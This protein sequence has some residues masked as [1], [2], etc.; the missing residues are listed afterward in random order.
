[1][2][3]RQAPRV[4]AVDLDGTL[5]SDYDEFGRP[6]SE[7]NL[8]ALS[9]LRAAGT[10]ILICT[11]RSES[12][13]RSILTRSG[14]PELAA[15]DLILQNGAL[16]LEG[17]T[18]RV[19]ASRPLSKEDAAEYLAIF[20]EHEMAPMLFLHH[21]LGGACL[22]EGLVTNPRQTHYLE[23]RAKED[24]GALRRVANLEEHLE[25]DPLSLATIDYGEPIEAARRDMENLALPESR[26]AVQGLVGW[27]GGE[28]A[29][30]LEVFHRDVR[31]EI[32]F[33]EYCAARE[34]EP[35]D[36]AAIGD[37]RN[38]LGLIQLCGF[39]IAMANAPRMVREAAD[40]IAPHYNES[41][42]ATA[43]RECFGL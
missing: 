35:A 13:A 16:V 22:Y 6:V 37:G 34:I 4:L 43:I 32:A 9:D 29:Q 40:H 17:G 21:D 31:K 25:R 20:R 33:Q 3:P 15:C 19:Q 2:V 24:A 11:G 5:I 28:P 27:A 1:M 8:A 38:D 36:C 23:I 7:E 26:V 12:S 39:G 18:G 42:L 10:R 30:F 14:D 41:G